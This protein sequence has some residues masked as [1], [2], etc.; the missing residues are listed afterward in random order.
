[1]NAALYQVFMN[2]K[3]NSD[4]DA[5]AFHHTKQAAQMVQAQHFSQFKFE[6]RLPAGQLYFFW[7]S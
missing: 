7:I 4:T 6:N 1:M 2:K 5:D 3:G